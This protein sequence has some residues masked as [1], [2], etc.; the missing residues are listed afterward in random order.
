ML[1]ELDEVGRKARGNRI[2]V[3]TTADVSTRDN[4]GVLSGFNG[5]DV[6]GNTNDEV[7]PTAPEVCICPELSE[8]ELAGN[9]SAVGD[10]LVEY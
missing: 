3:V 10:K 7:A 5:N 1:I 9:T 8:L 2:D 4:V 6:L